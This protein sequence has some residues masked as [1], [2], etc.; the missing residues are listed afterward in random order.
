MVGVVNVRAEVVGSLLRPDYL[1]K[2]RRQLEAGEV[3]PA[4]FK[5]IEDSLAKKGMKP[6]DASLEEM[7]AL[8]QEVKRAERLEK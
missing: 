5:A 3:D 6:E 1:A 2:A 7:E 4:R 8:W